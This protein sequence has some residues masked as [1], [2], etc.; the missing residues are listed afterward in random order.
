MMMANSFLTQ[1]NTR[2]EEATAYNTEHQA[3]EFTGTIFT[4]FFFLK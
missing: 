1:P 4:F 2:R 3:K